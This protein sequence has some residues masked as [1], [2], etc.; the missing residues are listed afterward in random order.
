MFLQSVAYLLNPGY[1]SDYGIDYSSCAGFPITAMRT[2]HA[3]RSCS[4]TESGHLL[5]PPRQTSKALV[6]AATPSAWPQYGT[7]FRF[8]GAQSTRLCVLALHAV[9]LG[10]RSLQ[11]QCR[12]T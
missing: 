12:M 7:A 6:T 1:C 2:E 4:G 10:L 5:S 3:Y 11:P 8:I 9:D